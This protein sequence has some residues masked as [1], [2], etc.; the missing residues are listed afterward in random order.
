MEVVTGDV[1]AYRDVLAQ[2]RQPHRESLGVLARLQEISANSILFLGMGRPE[3]GEPHQLGVHL[4]FFNH[5][6]IAGSDG[7][8]L[9]VRQRGGIKVFQAADR[10]IAAHD[11]RDELGFRFECLPHVGIERAFADVAVNLDDG[12][13][14]SLPEDAPF[15]LLH[16]GWPP[17]GIEMVKRNQPF[18]NVRARTHLLRTAKQD[19]N[20]ARAHV[21]EQRQL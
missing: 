5:Q 12:V 19:A 7:F 20:F 3:P 2:I 13:L 16:V 4:G 14:V 15:A 6:R 8:D 18:L 17:R 10:H 11:L 1:L 21:T 9:G